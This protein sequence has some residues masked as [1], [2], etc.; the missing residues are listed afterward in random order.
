MAEGTAYS[1][2]KDKNNRLLLQD[3][4]KQLPPIT[5]NFLEEKAE[6]NPNTAVAYARDLLVFFQYLRE[7][8][9]VFQK[10][11]MNQIT[12]E[13][14]EPLTYLDINEY[15]KF[16]GADHPEIVGEAGYS[17]GNAAKARRMSAL[18]GFFEYE[19]LHND[20]KSN[21]CDGSIK[22]KTRDSQHIITRLNVEEV[23]DL[24]YMVQTSNFSSAH[25]KKVA[26]KTHYRDYAI[27]VLL[28]N[29]G[30]R[31][32]ECVGLDLDH[33]SFRERK[34][35]VLRKGRKVNELYFNEDVE[36]ALRDYIELER[37]HYV[38]EE[39]EKALFLSLQKKRMTVRSIETMVEKYASVAV[40]G[41]KISPHKMRS[42][43]GTA[44]YN[45]TGDIRLVADVLGHNDINT[46]AS[47]YAAVEEQHRQ[48]AGKINLY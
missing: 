4:L 9:P 7:F 46:T 29:T 17:E 44:L 13:D 34:L 39:K 31:V 22:I 30:I 20:M 43:Y 10:K 15:I 14:L 6:N 45:E 38:F 16:L 47:H 26:E 37:P 18:R 35:T 2:E 48:A 3:L 36:N 40:S 11:E 27:F 21:P 8:S 25:Q 32:S 23:R 42:T 33:I 24:L 41:K 12:D 19:V 1:R 5:R 28:L